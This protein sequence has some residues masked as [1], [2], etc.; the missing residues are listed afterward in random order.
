[1]I[2]SNNFLESTKDFLLT[3]FGFSLNQ[4]HSHGQVSEVGEALGLG[5]ED[6]GP[7][8]CFFRVRGG[9]ER[10]MLHLW[11]RLPGSDAALH[12]GRL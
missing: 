5:G 2:I 7:R 3:M 4:R 10:V 12:P 8:N 6:V 1:M 11:V 9:K